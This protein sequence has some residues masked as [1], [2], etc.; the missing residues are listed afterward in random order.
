MLIELIIE[1]DLGSPGPLVVHVLL[2]LVIFIKK[3][4]SLFSCKNI[5]GG[6]VLC[7]TPPMPSRLQN[8][9]Q[10]RKVLNMFWN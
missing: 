5:A 4:K 10:K 1:L 2:K 6:N 8:N 9:T 3:Q 7:F